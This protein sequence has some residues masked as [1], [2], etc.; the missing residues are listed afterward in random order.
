MLEVEKIR[1]THIKTAADVFE[2]NSYFPEYCISEMFQMERCIGFSQI[3]QDEGET[4]TVDKTN[5]IISLKSN[6]Y[7]AM[8]TPYMSDEHLHAI[9]FSINSICLFVNFSSFIL[10]MDLPFQLTFNNTYFLI[11]DHSGNVHHLNIHDPFSCETALI[12]LLQ[13]L[14]YMQQHAG[15]DLKLLKGVFDIPIL[16]NSP[17]LGR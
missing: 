5:F 11:E 4:K 1:K 13:D 2:N 7:L 16:V 17:F 15:V 6:C 8:I 12:Y 10:N 14:K 9:I 3:F